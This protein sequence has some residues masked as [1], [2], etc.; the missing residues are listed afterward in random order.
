M[1]VRGEGTGVEILIASHR[2]RV[3]ARVIRADSYAA[4]MFP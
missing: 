4:E 2:G 3:E 1:R